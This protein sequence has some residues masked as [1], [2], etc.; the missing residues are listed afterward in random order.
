MN[1]LRMLATLPGR[2]RSLVGITLT[3]LTA[4]LIVACGGGGTTPDNRASSL[5]PLSAE[6]TSRK[7]VAYSP[8]R[9][10]T[11]EG[12]LAAEVI[13]E[14]NIKQD[15]DL[16]VQGG[17]GLIRLFDSDDKV[18]KGV[19]Q[20]IRKYGI[21]LKVQLGIYVQS[22]NDAYNR[23]QIDR[24]VALANTYYDIVLA[25]SVGNEN[26]VDFSFNKID[27]SVMSGYIRTLRPQISQPITTDDNYGFWDKADA[28][29]ADVVDFASIHVY[30]ELDT[31][32]V[33]EPGLFDW[34]QKETPEGQRAAAMMNASLAEARR[35]YDLARNNLDRLGRADIPITVGET[36]WNAVDLGRLKF[37]AHPVNQKMYYDGLAA[38]A[39][40]GRSGAG[41]KAI[42]YFEAFDEA[43][44]QGD[45]K[46]GLFNKDRQA[47]Y[48]VKDLY[49]ASIWEP[50][51]A[52]LTPASALYWKAPTVNTAVT[53]SKYLVYA[54]NGVPTATVA[55]SCNM[56]P[57]IWEIDAFD[58]SSAT[59]A[60][61]SSTA[62]P[63]DATHSCELTPNPKDYGWGV[64]YQSPTGTTEN[65]S[66]FAVA[67][68]LNL[69]IRTTYPGKIEIGLSTDTE[70]QGTTEAYIQIGNGDYGYCNTGAWCQVSIPI[71][72]FVALNP[73]LDL[74]LVV[75]R[76]VISDVYSRTGKTANSN[77]KTPIDFDAVYWSK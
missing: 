43:W 20:V 69:S 38:W 14:A 63:G 57:A 76:F 48:V 35:Q 37:R 27:P 26:M 55:N 5:R 52:A 34:R 19:L 16:L 30:P 49:P 17:F 18:G 73:K 64:L 33:P 66:A 24:A 31:V 3:G 9:S 29:I 23:A 54:E 39:A 70:E 44:K 61:I 22:G 13:P 51:T 8:Y 25:V 53:A 42:F 62:A 72:D 46:W 50:G 68:K 41:P 71:K 47:R 15:L 11:N 2:T 75:I 67:G 4:L 77:I 40:E 6:F 45:D 36:G 74:R 59:W 60:E 56:N 12:G 7:A 10:S 21:N 65:L 32:F 58:G 1:F 28:R